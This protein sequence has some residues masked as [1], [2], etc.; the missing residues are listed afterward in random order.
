MNKSGIILFMNK[1]YFP[2]TLFLG[3]SALIAL[4]LN[5]SLTL[6]AQNGTVAINKAGNPTN[7]PVI[8]DLSD[9]SNAHLGF[10]MPN[11]SLASVT[12]NTTIPSPATGLIVWNT[13]SGMPFGVGF[14]YWTGSQ[15]YFI[16]NS[17]SG[18]SGSGTTNYIAR[19]TSASTLGTGVAQDNGSGVSISSTALTPANMLD[20]NGN[21][22][23]GSYAGTAGPS[24][25]IILPG[26][27]GI[28]TSTPN[29][30][31][32]LDVTSIT[33]GL[34]FPRIS[35]ANISSISSPATGLIVYNSTTNCLE[36]YNG[37]SWQNVSCPCSSVPNAGAITG[38]TAL[39]ASSSGN[40]Y[41]IAA[42]ANATY[43]TWTVPAGAS[44]TAG[45]GTT[46]ITVTFGSTSGNI[47][48]TA[49]NSCGTG[50]TSNLAVTLY[51]PLSSPATPSGN[52]SPSFN[53]SFTYTIAPVSGAV[54]YTWSVSS[55]NATITSG[56]GT[57]SVSILFNS[58]ATTLN[59][60]VYAT[61]P[62]GNSTTSCLSVTSSCP[63]GTASFSFNGGNNYSGTLQTWT[64]PGCITSITIVATGGSGG[65]SGG[66]VGGLAAVVTASTTVTPGDVLNILVAGMGIE[67]SS[68]YGGGGGGGT[69]IWD[70][71]TTTL[72]VVA[73]GGGGAGYTG[74][75]P[76]QNAQSNI[77]PPAIFQS[78][79]NESGGAA[80]G[81][82][83]GGASSGG[84]VPTADGGGGGAGW[85]ESG[86]NNTTDV[87]YGGIYPLAG[88][89]PGY[90]GAGY[91]SN[92]LGGPGGYGGGG[93]GGYDGGAGGG[94]YNGGGSGNGDDG[95]GGGG[96]YFIGGSPTSVTLG[97]AN[98]NGS[99]IITY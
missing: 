67:V 53:S 24:N 41:S 60:C 78:P 74:T 16:M 20:V 85:G 61:N 5:F 52:T 34:L 2:K 48:V 77:G 11:V 35:T 58:T 93:G 43:Y 14:Y 72:L 6:F 99:V 33:Q 92:T 37:S 26:Q 73:G 75:V 27:M 13:N 96:N 28:G 22:A 55:T 12:D 95:G 84:T 1:N 4:F 7:N 49:S 10:L 18:L 69:Y 82:T 89:T 90:G 98:T 83:G 15:W 91:S 38:S 63:H 29:S 30:S 9:V 81:G 50:S 54:S 64:V 76:G 70:N 79:T 45:A 47:S 65:P 59:I 19:W 88:I 46:S 94:G 25:G 39:C 8:L 3:K 36:C 23:F 87:C 80:D 57:T 21:A 97:S 68:A 51:S 62:C 31:A 32:A 86:T 56:Q 44:I 66:G 40:V 71:N 17:N 42:V